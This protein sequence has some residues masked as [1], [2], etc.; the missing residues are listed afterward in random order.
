MRVTKTW[1]YY[2]VTKA[3]SVQIAKLMLDSRDMEPERA[4]LYQQW[5]YGVYLLW[6]DLTMGWQIPGAREQMEALTRR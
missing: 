3:A 1:S 2:D 5:A 6:N 4:A